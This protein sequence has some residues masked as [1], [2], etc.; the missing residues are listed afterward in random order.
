M[1]G[2]SGI[3]LGYFAAGLCQLVSTRRHPGRQSRLIQQVERNAIC[4]LSQFLLEVFAID[5]R[6]SE[7]G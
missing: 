7:G 5:G 3:R 4:L 6:T 1:R 2:E